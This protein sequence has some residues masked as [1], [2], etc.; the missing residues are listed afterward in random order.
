M[1]YLSSLGLVSGYNDGTFKPDAAMSAVEALLF[2]AR[3]T[4]IDSATKTKIAQAWEDTLKEIVPADML[5]WAAPDL[6]VC[7]ETGIIT[8]AELK[9]LA[10]GSG[11]L[12]AIHREK[13]ALYLARAMQIDGAAESLTE[14]ELTFADQDGISRDLRPYVYLLTDYGI[15]K[16]DELQPLPPQEQREPCLD[17]L[18]DAP[19]HGLYEGEG[20]H[21][22]AGRLHHL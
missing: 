15:L 9:A 21:G 10:N 5:T 3:V 22:G 8:S 18:S 19:C 12:N 4:G 14:Y 16:G 13:V 20:R 7:L 2:C 1:E 17:D 6:A 11:L